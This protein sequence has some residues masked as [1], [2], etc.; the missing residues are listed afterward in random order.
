MRSTSNR[1]APRQIV[2]ELALFFGIAYA[3]TWSIFGFYVIAPQR[4]IALLGAFGQ[5]NLWLAL[6]IAA[7]SVTALGLTLMREGPRGVVLTAKRI[8]MPRSRAWW[9]WLATAVLIIPAA[10]ALALLIAGAFRAPGVSNGWNALLT[11]KMFAFLP[12]VLLAPTGGATGEDLFG[13]RAYAV[14]RFLALIN[15]VATVLTFGTLW[16]VW[17]LPVYLVSSAA[18][19]TLARSLISFVPFYFMVIGTVSLSVWLH[20]RTEG[21]FLFSGWLLHGMTNASIA[22]IGLGSDKLIGYWALAVLLA[23]AVLIATDRKTFGMKPTCAYLTD[24]MENSSSQ[25]VRQTHNLDGGRTAAAQAGERG[26]QE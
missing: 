23:G 5:Q 10:A 13:W 21:N 20:I 12:V 7:P 16:A 3:I 14:P 24:A 25:S 11:A 22:M 26:S 18:V 2:I 1:H 15:P 17:H 8:L 19:G 6:G 4:A 9:G